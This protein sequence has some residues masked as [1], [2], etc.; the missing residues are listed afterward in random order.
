MSSLILSFRCYTKYESSSSFWGPPSYSR[1]RNHLVDIGNTCSPSNLIYL[2]IFF[3][4][5]K[6]VFFSI[7]WKHFWGFLLHI[8]NTVTKHKVKV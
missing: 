6:H 3:I 5:W 1:M 7:Y 2:G 8:G 4:Y